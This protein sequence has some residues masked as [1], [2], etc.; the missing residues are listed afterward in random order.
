[1][2]FMTQAVGIPAE[3]LGD[4][5]QDPSWQG[6][7]DIAHTIAYDGTFVADFMQGKPLPAGQF[8]NVTV[9]ALVMDGGKSM[10]G[11]MNGAADAIAEQLPNSERRTL[12]DQD[13]MVDPKV[14]APELE[15]FFKNN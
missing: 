15:K 12:K 13:H 7:L 5:D 11:W 3:Y 1:M 4:M 6:M 8:S 10:P 14:I 2:Y 9:P